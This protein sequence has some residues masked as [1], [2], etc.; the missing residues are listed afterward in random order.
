MPNTHNYTSNSVESTARVEAFTDGVF[1]II[2]TLLV[3][4][5]KVPVVEVA[6]SANLLHG[7][8][9][10]LP[11]FIAFF[12]SFFIIAIYWV[13]HH[14]FFHNVERA[15]WKLLWYN[16]FHLFWM[17]TIPF[18]TAFIGK[19]YDSVVAVSLYALDMAM[20]ALSF[21]LMIRYVFFQSDLM[22]P[23]FS[24]AKKKIEYKR[25]MRGVYLYLF[26]TAAAFIHVYL[27]IAIFIATPI[28]FVAPRLLSNETQE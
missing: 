15:D 24:L 2:A 13:N 5:L 20:C 9:E 8:A 16:N 21:M 12:F 25:G 28:L 23:R 27:A 10:L 1:A 3:L 14:H 11:E 22:E 4:E 26:A 6:S 7:L 19:Y 18:T 17:A